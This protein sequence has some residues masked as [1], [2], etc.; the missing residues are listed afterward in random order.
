MS[1]SAYEHAR[2]YAALDIA[3]LILNRKPDETP[4]DEVAQRMMSEDYV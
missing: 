3:R 2:P 4:I 1:R